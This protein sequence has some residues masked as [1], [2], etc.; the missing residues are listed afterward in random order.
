MHIT[1]TEALAI[2]AEFEHMLMARSILRENEAEGDWELCCPREAESRV[3]LTNSKLD[4]CRRLGELKGNFKFICSDPEEED[5]LSPGHVNRAM[6][7]Q[8]G[9]LYEV[10][11]GTSHLLQVE[12]PAECAAVLV[13]FLDEC[14]IR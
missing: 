1:E 12:K 8:Y 5:S 2:Q 7:A 4:L 13:A 6:H 10:I 3:Y 14:G 11:P 9:H